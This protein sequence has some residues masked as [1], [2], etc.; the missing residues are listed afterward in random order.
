MWSKKPVH[1][2]PTPTGWANK[3]G[4]IVTSNITT[5]LTH[6]PRVADKLFKTKLNMPFTIKMVRSVQKIVT[7]VIQIRR[8]IKIDKSKTQRTSAAL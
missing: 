5:K 1:T 7:A 6:K 3:Q 2:V 4:G 8:K